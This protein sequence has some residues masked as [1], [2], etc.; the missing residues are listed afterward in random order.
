MPQLSQTI[1]DRVAALLKR[2]P[3]NIGSQSGLLKAQ[4]DIPAAQGW[5]V[6]AASLVVAIVPNAN[7]PYRV[8]AAECLTKLYGRHLPGACSALFG[9]LTNLR[10]DF[11]AGILT[12]L[13]AQVS[14]QTFDDLLDHADAYL[15]AKRREPSGVL[16]GV[17]FEDTVRKLC[18][19]HSIPQ[20]GIQLDTLLSDLVKAG[21]ITA[22]ERKEGTTAAALRTAA[23][24]ARWIEFELDQVATV[25]RFTRR[26][27]REKLAA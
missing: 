22:L 4:A 11:E 3:S 25:L 19:K 10:D 16:A 14:A 15:E 26:L 24:H 23:T 27:I 17:V 13:E 18:D 7:H 5:C 8:A 6:S 21:V 12:N 20:N 2:P 1:N 9:L